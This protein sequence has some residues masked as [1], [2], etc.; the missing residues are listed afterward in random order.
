MHVLYSLQFN[1]YKKYQDTY[2][3]HIKKS[4]FN[5]G[6]Q[7]CD[8]LNTDFENPNSFKSLIKKYGINFFLNL[9]DI[10]Y[11]DFP[12]PAK[13]YEKSLDILINNHKYV[14]SLF[15]QDLM[16]DIEYIFNMNNL[17]EIKDL[18]PLQRFQ[19]MANSDVS[20]KSLEKIDNDKVKINLSAFEILRDYSNYPMRQDETQRI[21]STAN[22]NSSYFIECADII[23]ALLIE[24]LE[25]AKLNIEIKK[26]RNCGKFFVPDNRSDEIYCSNI[27]ENGKTCKEIGHFK[28]QQKLIQENDDLR[29]YRNVY[30]KLL[31]RTRINPT[32]TK[33]AREFEFFKDDNNKWRENI[34]K[35]I[36]TEK[37]YIEWLKKQ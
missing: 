20:S 7:L 1:E 10:K 34:S 37:E 17:E 24:L 28:V 26:C 18:T 32:N 29:I 5:I 2:S 35:G 21:V 8:F 3:S 23:Q 16:L 11:S 9:T 13:E 27:Y 6:E 33:Y 15:R 4:E 36:S 14:F 30:Q 12:V 25:I 22:I 31:L 19:V